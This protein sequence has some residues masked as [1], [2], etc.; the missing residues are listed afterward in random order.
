M[1]KFTG[2]YISWF[3]KDGNRDKANNPLLVFIKSL[4]TP[5]HA[6]IV[7]LVIICFFDEVA[8]LRNQCQNNRIYHTKESPLSRNYETKSAVL[9]HKRSNLSCEISSAISE[10]LNILKL[11]RIRRSR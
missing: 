3:L 8:K 6:I 2:G 7:F 4:T 5:N 11:F 9:I 1:C 10:Y